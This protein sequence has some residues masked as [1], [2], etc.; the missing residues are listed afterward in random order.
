MEYIFIDFQVFS[1]Y[2]E[3]SC[4]FLAKVLLFLI[5]VMD[6]ILD[7][8]ICSPTL[9]EGKPRALWGNFVYIN[10]SCFMYLLV[11]SHLL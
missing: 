1:F 3:I 5:E 11:H 7:V 9:Q 2:M 10:P 4:I 8:F 6:I